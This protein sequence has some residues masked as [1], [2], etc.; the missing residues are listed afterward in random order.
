MPMTRLV[1]FLKKNGV[2]HQVIP[3][4]L[5]FTARTVAGAA[6]IPGRELAKTVVVDRGACLGVRAPRDESRRD[7]PQGRA[8]RAT[9]FVVQ[10]T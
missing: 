10:G 4:R 9:W 7:A 2:P 1:E 6:H 3:H 8:R 5:A